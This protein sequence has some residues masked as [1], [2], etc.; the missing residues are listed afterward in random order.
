MEDHV[1]DYE[2][3][4]GMPPIVDEM[5]ENNKYPN[6]FKVGFLDLSGSISILQK[7]EDWDPDRESVTNGVIIEQFEKALK[8]ELLKPQS[9]LHE[10]VQNL[11]NLAEQL[12]ITKT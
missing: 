6:L 5:T 8:S 12:E 4:F 9:R 3:T 1:D 11:T 7:L 2:D 10:T